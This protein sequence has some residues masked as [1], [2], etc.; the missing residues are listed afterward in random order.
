MSDRRDAILDTAE[1]MIRAQGYGGFSFRDVAAAVGI[2][3]ASVHYHF[4]TKPQLAAAV[5]RRYRDRFA[6]ALKAS[7]AQGQGRVVAWQT[8]FRQALERDGL[9]CLCGILAVEGDSLPPEVAQEA[10]AFL[11]FGIASLDEAQPG[12]GARILAQLEGAMLIARS[13]EDLQ[14]F[15]AATADL[16]DA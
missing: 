9:M 16:A 3:S 5:A 15:T 8:L 10:R 12:Q 1:R 11:E 7:E 6:T 13:A 14:L 4:P 2:K